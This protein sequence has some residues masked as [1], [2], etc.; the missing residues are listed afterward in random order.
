M[1]DIDKYCTL[2]DIVQTNNTK[3]GKLLTDCCMS[4]AVMKKSFI[5]IPDK[6]I[7][8]IGKMSK[9]KMKNSLKDLI[10]S[11][12]PF[13]LSEIKK[14]KSIKTIRGSTYN[15]TVD[16]NKVMF[17]GVEI[18]EKKCLGKSPNLH[19]MYEAKG[20]LIANKPEPIGRMKVLSMRKKESKK[21][22]G[23]GKEKINTNKISKII[24]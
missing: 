17:N 14:L 23:A 12:T 21:N 3:I 1:T 18:I 4:G 13:E 7:T 2:F 8:K 19:I 24:F 20:I 22:K 15:I 11:R 16:K 10:L 5:M 6:E 9:E